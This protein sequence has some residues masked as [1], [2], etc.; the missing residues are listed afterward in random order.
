MMVSGDVVVVR[1]R[2][3]LLVYGNI[4]VNRPFKGV[5]LEAGAGIVREV[6]A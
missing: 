6:P 1:E 4:A 5:W 2:W 3:R